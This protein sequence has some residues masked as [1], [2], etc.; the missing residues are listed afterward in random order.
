[1]DAKGKYFVGGLA[2][3]VKDTSTGEGVATRDLMIS[4][5]N[6]S[7]NIVFDEEAAGGLIGEAGKQLLQL[8]IVKALLIFH[9]ITQKMTAIFLS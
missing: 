5:C 2:G 3:Y 8:I 4:N 1:M 9:G 6:T 7:G